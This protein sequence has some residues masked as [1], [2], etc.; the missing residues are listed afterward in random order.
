MRWKDLYLSRGKLLRNRWS[1]VSQQ[2]VDSVY[3][4]PTQSTGSCLGKVE[5]YSVLTHT[6]SDSQWGIFLKRFGWTCDFQVTRL[7]S[8][9]LGPFKCVLRD[10][11]RTVAAGRVAADCSLFSLSSLAACQQ[12]NYSRLRDLYIL[13][14]ELTAAKTSLGLCPL[15]AY[16]KSQDSVLP[17]GE[18]HEKLCL[19]KKLCS[20][21]C[22]KERLKDLSV[23]F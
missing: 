5:D 19:V 18:K 16:S 14:Q 10:R 1:V 3:L 22:W 2:G 11:P 7:L 8:R 23:R 12:H 9:P 20:R 17:G 4:V 6:R 13:Q 15:S 21:S